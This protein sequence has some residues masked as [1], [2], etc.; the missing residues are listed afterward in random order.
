MIL[1]TV[2]FNPETKNCQTHIK[3]RI[4]KFLSQVTFSH[5]GWNYGWPLHTKQNKKAIIDWIGD[6]KHKGRT[7][8]SGSICFHSYFRSTFYQLLPSG[9]PEVLLT[10]SRIKMFLS[11]LCYLPHTGKAS[12]FLT[13]LLMDSIGEESEG[14]EKVSQEKAENRKPENF[15]GE[16]SCLGEKEWEMGANAALSVG[17]KEMGRRKDRKPLIS[18][19]LAQ[20]REQ[21]YICKKS[22]SNKYIPSSGMERE[23]QQTLAPWRWREMGLQD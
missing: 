3:K 19:F 12:A 22:R 11:Q 17:G 1:P 2:F 20:N 6:P 10:A 23:I 13:Y 21:Q 18:I 4:I 15:E 9:N 5:S 8:L 7:T 16:K 14:K